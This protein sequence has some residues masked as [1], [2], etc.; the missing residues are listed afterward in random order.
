MSLLDKIFHYCKDLFI[1]RRLILLCMY[2]GGI[3]FAFFSLFLYSVLIMSLNGKHI[4]YV[5]ALPAISPRPT[6]GKKVLKD[7]RL[8]LLSLSRLSTS[9]PSPYKLCLSLSHLIVAG[10]C[11]ADET[12][13]VITIHRSN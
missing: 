2:T 11:A 3:S 9:I 1:M 8:Y 12:Q 7:C 4:L 13:K 6:A 10:L 5:A